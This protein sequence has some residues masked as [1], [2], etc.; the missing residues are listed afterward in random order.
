MMTC[1]VI[2]NL[3]FAFF[4]LVKSINH[5]KRKEIVTRTVG[6]IMT[7]YGLCSN[8]LIKVNTETQKINSFLFIIQIEDAFNTLAKIVEKVTYFQDLEEIIFILINIE[9]SLI[10][11]EI[12]R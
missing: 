5:K 11:E 6:Y 10:G 2:T 8:R 7:V 1:N 12:L 9:V 4:I 3:T